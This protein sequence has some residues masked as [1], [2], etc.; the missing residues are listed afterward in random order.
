MFKQQ[1]INSRKT[2]SVTD[3]AKTEPGFGYTLNDFFEAAMDGGLSAGKAQLFDAAASAFAKNFVQNRDRKI[4]GCGVSLVEAVA[5]A[6]IAPI[7]Q[8]NDKP[9]HRF[10]PCSSCRSST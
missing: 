4:P 5:A 8:L 1:R 7:G 3:K 6:Q 2:R 10:F 9:G